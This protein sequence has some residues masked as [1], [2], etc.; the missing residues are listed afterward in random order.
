MVCTQYADE[1][2]GN[3]TFDLEAHP[4]IVFANNPLKVVVAQIR[5]PA[6]FGLTEPAALAAIQARLGQQYP[7]ALARIPNITVNVGAGPVPETVV[8]QGPTRL[9]SEDGQW[10]INI[11]TDW[12]S[13]ETLGY[14]SWAGFRDRFQELL[15]AVPDDVRPARASRIGL[16]YVDQLQ[17]PGVESPADWQ[18]FIV[19]ALIGDPASLVFDERL[20]TALQQLSFRIDDDAINVRHGYV[21]NGP[22]ADYP[23]TYVIDS[24]LFTEIESPFEWN[25]IAEKLDRYHGWAWT[26]F[27]RSITDAAVELLGGTPE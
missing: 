19:R 22:D 17:A 27:R 6:Q 3:V 13:L 24:D 8:D 5:F 21:R 1:Q 11:A 12:I 26:I 23:S 2:G 4:R 25:G 10:V 9:A 7:T 18:A 20:V 15:A 16:R 14:A